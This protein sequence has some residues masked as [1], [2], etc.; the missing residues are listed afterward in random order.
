MD[1]WLIDSHKLIYHPERVAQWLDAD[2]WEKAKHVYPIYFEITTSAACNHR[3]LAGDTPVNT[4]YGMTPIRELVGKNVPVLTYDG[5]DVFLSDAVNVRLIEH[6]AELMRVLFDDGTHIDCTPDHEF[7]LIKPGNHIRATEEIPTQAQDL[8][9]GASVRAVRHTPNDAGYI[10]THW[11]RRGRRMRSRIVM[12]YLKGRKLRRSEMVHHEDHDITN[13]HPSNLRYCASHKDHSEQHPEIAQRMRENNPARNMT[14]QW[15]EKLR[16]AITGKKRTLAQ[17]IRYRNSKL[18]AR[19]PNFKGKGWP[20]KSRIAEINH[21]VVGVSRLANRQDVFCLEVPATGWFFA[22]DVLVK[23]C[24]FC[25]V[26][27]IGYPPDLLDADKLIATM[28]EAKQL[29]VKSVMFAGTGEPLI[30]KRISDITDGAVDCGLDVAFTTNGV[31]LDKL[32]P[33]DRC[34]WIKVSLNAGTPATYAAVHQTDEKDWDRVWTGIRGAV[35]RKGACTIGVQCVVLP[36]NVYEMKALAGLCIEAGVDYLVL[37]PYSQG[38]FSLTHKYEDVD[39]S[40]MRA[41]LRS[42]VEFSTKDFKVIYRSDSINQEIEKKH[43]Y[44]KCRATPVFWCYAMG[45]GDIFTC[46]A[47]LLDRRFCIG[48]INTQT[49]REI[50]EGDKRRENWELMQSFDIKQC[51][52]NCRMERP[53]RYLADFSRVPHRNFI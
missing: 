45:N 6:D 36:E 27:A 29:G 24:T 16:K 53:N 9:H 33:V 25:S 31:L 39:Y 15:R 7:L 18:G 26:D 30:H 8:S 43:G 44:D 21:K 40:A 52:L 11:G 22:N 14:A 32:R 28:R 10:T 23:N 3:C 50:W 46:S 34:T 17:R 35:K 48:N 4:I 37:K 13:D 42:V 38:T 51:R 20:H 47:H 2:T 41:Y 12:D 19:N 5:K 1:D 49:F